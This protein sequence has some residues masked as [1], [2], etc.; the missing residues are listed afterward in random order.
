[1]INISKKLNI[2]SIPIFD[3][4]IKTNLIEF[5]NITS[6]KFDLIIAS[7]S[8]HYHKELVSI[9]N[10]AKKCLNAGGMMAFSIEKS[11][12]FDLELNH[13][14]QNYCFHRQF[15]ET[16][17]KQAEFHQ[18]HMSEHKINDDKN[19]WYVVISANSI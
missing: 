15:I 17:I 13:S 19:Y 10:S 18:L 11:D 16:S 1:M 7:D 5:L 6:K 8:L 4:L 3:N 9:L 2:K 12:S 14:M